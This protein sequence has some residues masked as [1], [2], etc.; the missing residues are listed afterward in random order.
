MSLDTLISRLSPA[1]AARRA[2]RRLRARVT[3]E[4]EQAL[5]ALAA[6]DAAEYSRNTADWNTR[7]LSSDQAVVGDQPTAIARARDAVRNDWAAVSIVDGHVR[8]IVGIGITPRANA[9]HPGTGKSLDEFNKAADRIWNRWARD[10][11]LCHTERHW[12]FTGLEALTVRE[13]VTA[14]ISIALFNYTPR[15]DHVGVHIQIIEFEQLV[16]WLVKNPDTGFWIRNGVEIDD[17]GAPVALWVFT[18]G[19]PL[20][21]IQGRMAYTRIPF[22]RVVM[23]MRPERV[24]Q[25]QGMGRLS[26]VLQPLH[27]NKLYELYSVLRA[28]AECVT[29]VSIESDLNASGPGAQAGRFRRRGPGSGGRGRE[30]VLQPNMINRL[31]PGEHMN[32]VAPTTPGSQYAPFSR[33]QGTKFAA[34]AGLDYPTVARDF[35]GMTYSGQLQG[36][37]E[38]WAETDPAQQRMVDDFCRPIRDKVITMA[39]LEGRLPAP[40]FRQ[41]GMARCVPGGR[42]AGAG[43]GQHQ[44]GAR[45]RRR[46]DR[47]RLQTDHPAGNPQ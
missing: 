24:R 12:N 44:P 19:H 39:I 29:G 31:A 2:E 18:K 36:R 35:S 37:L 16:A 13:E 38:T 43:E 22:D 47:A 40:E 8:H 7:L 1:W 46:Q 17:F 5:L 33:T 10:K 34:G 3:E 41:P 45:P 21:Y 14:G 6:H 4:R 25:S 30:I 15:A 11:N 20:E 42:V 9:R 26:A 28:R 23:T 32:F 27:H